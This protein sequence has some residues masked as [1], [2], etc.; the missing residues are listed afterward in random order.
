MDV[1]PIQGSSIPCERVFSSGKET[2]TARRS[3]I[4]PELME[5]LQLLEFSFWRGWFLNL[6]LVQAGMM[7]WLRRRQPTIQTCLMI[8]ILLLQLW[9][10]LFRLVFSYIHYCIDLGHGRICN[11]FIFVQFYEM[12]RVLSQLSIFGSKPRLQPQPSQIKSQSAL[13]APLG[14]SSKLMF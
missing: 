12:K 10:G 3:R 6:R 1:L 7:S 9:T 2:T 13:L 5:G 4:S 8:W 11:Y 14:S